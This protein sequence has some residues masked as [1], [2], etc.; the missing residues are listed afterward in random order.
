[1][2]EQSKPSEDP[3]PSPKR[4]FRKTKDILPDIDPDLQDLL[5]LPV[6]FPSLRKESKKIDPIEAQIEKEVELIQLYRKKPLLFWRD[7][8]G[9]PIDNWRD[10]RPPHDWS[11]GYPVPLWTK[12]KEIIEALV[13]HKK[14]TVKSGHGVGKT[15]LAAGVALY[16][17][18]VWRA[19]G[20]TTAPTF[21]QVRRALWGEIHYQYNRARR[22][23]GGKLNQVSLDLGDKWFVE[24]FA[25][26]KPMENITGI[27]EECVFI[28]VD[29]AGGC[30][31]ETFDA[32]EGLLTSESCFVLYIGNPLDARGPFAESFKPG[33]G[34]YQ[35]TISC[36]DCPNVKHHKVIYP[37][38]TTAQWVKDKEKK[39]G[40][41]SNL[42]RIRVLGEFPEESTDTLIPIRYIE[43]AL[44]KCKEDDEN[45]Y[46][47]DETPLSF[48]LDVARLGSDSSAFSARFP[49][50][51]FKVLDM[52]T[53]NRG[54]EV[55]GRMKSIYND[56]FPEFPV[57]PSPI[58]KLGEKPSE[59]DFVYP[60][61]NV[62][63]IGVGGGTTDIL[64]E[65]G[66]PV[67]GVNVGENPDKLEDPEEA[68]MFLNKRAQY[69]WKLKKIFEDGEVAIDDEELALELTKLKVEFLRSGKIKII[70]KEKIKKDLGRSPDRAETM[71]LCYSMEESISSLDLVRF[72]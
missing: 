59:D 53:K 58:P 48:G 38:L 26:D 1:M 39:W 37:K 44:R 60:P 30:L 45:K 68:K 72:I 19:T 65:D 32:L 27:H 21:R 3:L 51:Y 25:T 57:P 23:L 24:G 13:S 6:S 71:M 55:A 36:Y 11:P 67:N 9:I 29:E 35:T 10:D 8:L 2:P 22:P 33:S 18:Y 20:V 5:D 31:P 52:V 15:F 12:Q 69:Y 50:K 66:F 49:S 42:F 34:F 40:I 62:D 14:V 70:D 46:N 64:L 43:T 63:D 28:V 17:G 56:Y 47:V 61:I 54:T 16:L 4:S 7:E 41:S